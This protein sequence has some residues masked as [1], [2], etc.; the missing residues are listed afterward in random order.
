MADQLTEADE[1]RLEAEAAASPESFRK[2][3]MVLEHKNAPAIKD[4][5]RKND[6]VK[7]LENTQR[8]LQVEAA[9]R[10]FNLFEAAPTNS[11]GT[12][13]SVAGAGPIDTYDPIIVSLLRR[14]M[15]N[16]IAYDICGVQTMT[17]PTGLVFAKR[18]R[19]AN[20]S[21]NETFYNEPNTG[22]SARGGSNTD[23][24]S[25]GYG[26]S[27]A[28]AT[29]A[30]GAANN[31]GTQ[32]GVSNNAGNS[33]YNYA[34]GLNR[35]T[36][37]GLG[38][39]ST[40]IFPEMSFTIEKTP[41]TAMARGLKAEY[42]ME[43]AQDLKAIHGL[44]ADTELSNDIVAEILSEIN[45]EVVRTIYVT[46]VPGAQVD[47]TTPGIFDLDVDSN[48]RW[49]VEKFKGLMFNFE[50]DANQIAKDTRRGRGNLLICSS[51]VASALEMTG[52]LSY[53]PALDGNNL[54]VDDTGPT[55]VGVLNGKYKVF[56]DPYAP[57]GFNFYVAGYKGASWTDAGLFYCP[58]VPLQKVTAVDPNTFQ[59]KLAF[60]TRYGM[61]ANPYAEGLTKGLGEI[62]QDT[63]LY[64]RRV[65]VN[66]LMG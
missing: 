27:T 17:G 53:T 36:I 41:V 59:P 55:F 21:G 42:S 54:A 60:K 65:I 18:T 40:A 43:L 35:L 33:T 20:Q 1:A 52:K 32:F 31:V 6:L 56:I 22:F 48:G 13:S 37:E 19:L 39:N 45:R 47:T 23:P 46:A 24:V 57:A 29:L 28:N 62:K 9:H 63:N 61:V 2:W 58:Y 66:H 34:G 7:I 38:G 26:N 30:G 50:R 11:M 16:L 64:Y 44:D 10:S 51:D 25:A 4:R 15:P 3:K 5:R 14:A 12:S 49:S 8:E